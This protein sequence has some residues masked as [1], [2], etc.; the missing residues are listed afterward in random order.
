MKSIPGVFDDIL[1]ADEAIRLTQ[2]IFLLIFFLSLL[3]SY[4]YTL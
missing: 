1:L 2:F 3:S 4:T